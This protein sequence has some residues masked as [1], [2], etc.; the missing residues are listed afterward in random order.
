LR[1]ERIWSEDARR[2]V[3]YFVADDVESLLYVVNLGS[4]PLHVWASALPDLARPD[5]AVLDLDPKEAPFE[6][7]VRIAR[8]LGSLCHEVGLPSHPKTTG[9]R[10]LHV[11]VPLG[12]QLTHA[13]ARD[14]AQVLCRK[15]T[16]EMP[17]IATMARSIPARGGRVYLDWLQNGQGKTIV[18]P[19]SVRPRP[20][21]PVSTPLSWGEVTG[22]LDPAR[23][24][25]Q[26]VPRRLRQTGEDPM[27]R[28]LEEK[29][30]L[31]AA[32][33]RLGEMLR[34]ED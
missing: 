8:R 3:A 20:G 4:I 33:G 10:G 15:V 26:S 30:D 16:E 7:V 34:P 19:F 5:W 22:R 17:E 12:R 28:V 13:Q 25:I 29:P 14:L 31:L 21:A 32:L 23:F 11:L 27:R 1:T 9:Q 6:H 2:E 18:A 24:T